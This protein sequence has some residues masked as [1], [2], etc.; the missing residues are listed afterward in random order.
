MDTKVLPRIQINKL[1]DWTYLDK[2]KMLIYTDA[3]GKQNYNIKT[4][5]KINREAI[6]LCVFSLYWFQKLIDP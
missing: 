5:R 3:E 2:E 1:T 6:S 4:I